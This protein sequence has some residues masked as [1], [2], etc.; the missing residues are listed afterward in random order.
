MAGTDRDAVN[1]ALIGWGAP[2]AL[3]ADEGVVGL[4]L[5]PSSAGEV[6]EIEAGDPSFGDMEDGHEELGNAP[7]PGVVLIEPALLRREIGCDFVGDE[8]SEAT[9]VED[10]Q[11]RKVLRRYA[12]AP[13]G[14]F[15]RHLIADG[16]T[17]ARL[18]ALRAE[19]PNA[20]SLIEIVERACLLSLH[21][22]APL[23][24]PPLL[25][26]G[27]PGTGKSR[28]ARRLAEIIGTTL[29]VID[30]GS[31]TDRGPIVGHDPGYRGSSPGKVATSLLDGSTASPLILLDEICK[32][33]SYSPT[34]RPLDAL[35]PLF[36]PSTARSFIDTYIGLPVRADGVLW[37]MTANTVDRLPAPLLDRVV[38]VEMPPLSRAETRHVLRS[39]FAEV[40]AE[41]GLP[42]SHL[43]DAAVK[44]LERSG[45]RVARRILTL[46]LGPALAAGRA[47][48]DAADV[49]AAA[50][51]TNRPARKARRPKQP[52][53]PSRRQIGFVHFARPAAAAAK[54]LAASRPG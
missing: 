52:K 3:K 33:S 14:L 22:G 48:P 11:R 17:L 42:V 21:A 30:G 32:V 49:A 51:L 6:K 37:L 27:M 29:T 35:L 18:A 26:V 4:L 53:R 2:S 44:R 45:L 5:P 8:P 24:L 28:V 36:E 47:A 43:D 9:S 41:H 23:R 34:V 25:L 12:S 15:R 7:A 40:M 19:A 46:A 54:R 20:A 39:V 13:G 38:V 10:E 50:A 1:E 16:A 31:T